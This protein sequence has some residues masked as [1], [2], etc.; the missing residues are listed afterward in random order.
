MEEAVTVLPILFN[1]TINDTDNIAD[2]SANSMVNT[3]DLEWQNYMKMVCLPC[4]L[5]VGLFGNTVSFLV[6]SS[7]TYRRKSYSYY[8]RALAVTDTLALLLIT[9]EDVNQITHHLGLLDRGILYAHTD[10]TC[11]LNVFS[12]HV[13]NVM[14]SWLV[15]CFTIDRYIAVCHPLYRARLCRERIAVQTIALLLL[16]VC[17]SQSYHLVFV[18]HDAARPREPC[19]AYGTKEQAILYIELNYIWYNMTLLFGVPFVIMLAC[20]GRIICHISYMANIQTSEHHRQ[21]KKVSLAIYTLYA[22]CFTFVITLLP[23]AVLSLIQ[24]VTYMLLHSFSLLCHL[25]Q[26]SAPFQMIRLINYSCNFVLYGLTGR[27][28]RL[29]A[30]EVLLSCKRCACSCRCRRC[31]DKTDSSCDE[32]DRN[33]NIYMHHQPFLRAPAEIHVK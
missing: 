29:E 15:V 19:F 5:L 12:Y 2:T 30:K 20:N 26:L 32:Q 3:C 7:V 1:E 22:V 27:R 33:Q 8:L 21:P 28:F 23:N 4:F 24:Y 6:M 31:S 11:K 18:T 25:R 9:V 13:V 14:S 17:A 16:A 10:V